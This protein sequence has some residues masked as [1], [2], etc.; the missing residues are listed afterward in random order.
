MVPIK[1]DEK[2]Q[3]VAYACKTLEQGES[4]MTIG[5]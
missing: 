5:I 1:P 4:T 2:A 3:S